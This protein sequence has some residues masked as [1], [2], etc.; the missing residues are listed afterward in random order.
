MYKV[1]YKRHS[2]G[3]SLF[4]LYKVVMSQCNHFKILTLWERGVRSYSLWKETRRSLFWHLQKRHA[5][6]KIKYIHQVWIHWIAHIKN[7]L[8]KKEHHHSEILCKN[9]TVERLLFNRN[10]KGVLSEWHKA[11]ITQTECSVEHFNVGKATK[12]S[13][14]SLFLA[15]VKIENV[16]QY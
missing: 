4:S 10:R 2:T 1:K 13:C 6:R 16:N 15:L 7:K 5:T 8:F 9:L 3:F 11:V 12:R 14:P